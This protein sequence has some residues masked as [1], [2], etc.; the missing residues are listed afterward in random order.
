[1]IFPVPSTHEL[2]KQVCEVFT[3]IGNCIDELKV[4]TLLGG[5]SIQEDIEYFKKNTP[6]V[7]IGTSG[8]TCDMIQRKI[9]KVS[10]IDLFILDEADVMLSRGFKENIQSI[11][12]NLSKSTQIVLFS[13]TMP[14]EV[15]ELTNKFMNDPVKIILEAEKLSLECIQQY[16]IAIQNDKDKFDTLKDLFS[17]LQVNQSII[18][19][20]TIE[21]VD[22]LYEAMIKDGFQ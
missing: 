14:E 10:N 2:V 20:N 5:T 1:M 11:V 12:T 15:L 9:L 8:R 19:V 13:A 18:Y 6:Q 21:R 16:F 3:N 17:V 7:V 22:Q 4:K